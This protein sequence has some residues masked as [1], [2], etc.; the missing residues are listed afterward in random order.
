MDSLAK[1]TCTP[2]RGGMSPLNREEAQRLHVQGGS[3]F[4]LDRLRRAFTIPIIKPV[5]V[6]ENGTFESAHHHFIRIWIHADLVRVMVADHD[7]TKQRV[8]FIDEAMAVPL[9]CR[10][11]DVIA[12]LDAV[13][14]LAEAERCL[15]FERNDV[16]FL[17]Q[18]IMEWNGLLARRQFHVGNADLAPFH[19]SESTR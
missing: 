9:S 3:G 16:L 4:T 18:M 1:K 8:A 5:H 15:A 14:T 12:G 7:E 6:A 17:K 19:V 2:C 11:S 13:A 10:K